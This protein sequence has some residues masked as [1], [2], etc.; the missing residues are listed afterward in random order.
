MEEPLIYLIWNCIKSKQNYFIIT[1]FYWN[2]LLVT[3]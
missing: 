3:D 1:S 2:I